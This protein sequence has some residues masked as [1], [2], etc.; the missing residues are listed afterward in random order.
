MWDQSKV[1]QGPWVTQRL[2]F[3]FRVYVDLR[4]RKYEGR[5]GELRRLR[6]MKT[7][8]VECVILNARWLLLGGIVD[9]VASGQFGVVGV[10]TGLMAMALGA[11]GAMFCQWRKER[12][13]WML[14]GL[15]LAIYFPIF[16]A[17][18]HLAL[19][20]LAQVGVPN[21]SAC[22]TCDIWIADLFLAVQILFLET[23]TRTNWSLGKK[24]ELPE[25]G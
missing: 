18:V 10:C 1:R 4:H 2:Q 14:S 21:L 17:L 22:D 12:G 6:T 7:K 16:V 3:R 25:L 5:T 23:V 13:L 9:S 8:H 19:S 20:D 11:S 24:P 15:F